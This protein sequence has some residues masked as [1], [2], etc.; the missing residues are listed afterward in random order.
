MAY[1]KSYKKNRRKKP[2]SKA[3]G[4]KLKRPYASR[5]GYRL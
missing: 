3:K 2:Y 5:G 1:R 4:N